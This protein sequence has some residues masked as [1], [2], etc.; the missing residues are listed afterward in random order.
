M[1][2][3]QNTNEKVVSKAPAAAA[4]IVA[5]AAPNKEVV[6]K[7]R[8]ISLANLRKKEAMSMERKM[9]KMMPNITF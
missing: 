8:E 1:K 9:R 6:S 2:M 3:V 7:E 4:T 5:P